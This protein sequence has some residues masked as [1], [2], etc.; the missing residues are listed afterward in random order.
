MTI[1]E[2]EQL[3]RDLNERGWSVRLDLHP[4]APFRAYTSDY[5]GARY[6]AGPS[7]PGKKTTWLDVEAWT[8]EEAIT[9]LAEKVAAAE[10]SRK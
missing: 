2:L 10:R 5:S 6:D 4:N 1:T 8:I 9:A 3:L 7:Y